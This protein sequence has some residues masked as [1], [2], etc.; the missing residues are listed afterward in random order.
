MAVGQL[1]LYAAPIFC[2]VLFHDP[3]KFVVCPTSGG[4]SLVAEHLPFVQ[5]LSSKVKASLMRLHWT[6]VSLSWI[7]VRSSSALTTGAIGSA[8]YFLTGAEHETAIALRKS[9]QIC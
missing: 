8:P 4:K 5:Q 2:Q 9:Y 1:F 3:M 6:S 7:R